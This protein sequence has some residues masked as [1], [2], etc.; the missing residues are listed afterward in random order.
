MKE[1]LIAH[2]HSYIC[3]DRC[4]KKKMCTVRNDSNKGIHVGWG[5]QREEVYLMRFP[6][7]VGGTF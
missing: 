3:F 4:Y 7:L 1:K 2:T 5:R 6:S